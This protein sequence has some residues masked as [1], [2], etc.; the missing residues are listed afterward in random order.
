MH[1][2]VCF[3]KNKN[4]PKTLLASMQYKFCTLQPDQLHSKLHKL[5][6]LGLI[7][8]LSLPGYYGK[9]CAVSFVP[10]PLHGISFAF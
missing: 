9:M 7:E 4:I 5:R 8:G 10:Q 6:R 2:L 3:S 1:T